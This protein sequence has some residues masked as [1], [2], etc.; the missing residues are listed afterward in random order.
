MKNFFNRSVNYSNKILNSIYPTN[1]FVLKNSF[2]LISFSFDDFPDSA[3]LTGAKILVKYNIHATYYI[4]L[5][6]IGMETVVGKICD[7]D[8]IQLL[9]KEGHEIGNHTYDHYHIY[10]SLGNSFEDSILKNEQ[11]YKELFSGNRFETFAY[12]FGIV[13]NETKRIASK[14]FRCSRST[15]KGVNHGIIDIHT[16]KA[17]SIYG[18]GDELDDIKKLI[19]LTIKKNGWLNLYTHDVRK[20]HSLFGCTPEYFENVV[21]LA[22]DSGAKIVTIQEACNILGVPANPE[23]PR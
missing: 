14:Y 22:I 15:N 9:L 23:I 1:P 12:P 11:K 6:T 3:A 4:S 19:N 16:I 2:P 10:K 20:N 7:F 17:N 8:T 13:S 18:N 21:K 5:G